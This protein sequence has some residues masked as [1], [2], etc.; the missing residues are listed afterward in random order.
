MPKS[1]LFERSFNVNTN[2]LSWAS[3]TTGEGSFAGIDDPSLLH[4]VGFDEIL[5]PDDEVIIP[6]ALF[7]GQ[8]VNIDVDF[9]MKTVGDSIDLQAIIVDAF[10]NAV[11]Q[12]DS[13]ALDDGSVDPFDPNFSFTASTT[14]LYFLVIDEFR[15]NY[16][17]DFEF[18]NDGEDTGS[19]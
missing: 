15:N 19:F 17:G 6:V 12:D 14:G 11:R 13:G 2:F 8:T 9:G 16:A 10:G 4:Y 5:S 3:A 1:F 7:A 18:E